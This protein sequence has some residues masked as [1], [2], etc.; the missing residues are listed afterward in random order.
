MITLIV[1]K[2]NN[3]EK[4][5]IVSLSEVVSSE[6]HVEFEVSP[7]KN[8]KPGE[9]NWANYIKGCVANFICQFIYY[10]DF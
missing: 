1:G 6:N 3:L 10:L 2:C 8:I 9:P 7:R 4:C 5:N